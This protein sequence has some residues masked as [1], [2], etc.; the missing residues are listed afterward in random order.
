MVAARHPVCDAGS[1]FRCH[2]R[3]GHESPQRDNIASRH[4][5]AHGLSS[6]EPSGVIPDCL[7]PGRW[8][9]KKT[10]GFLPV[11]ILTISISKDES[12][13]VERLRYGRSARH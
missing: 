7:Q 4:F 5:A 9:G 1:G 13:V 2:S 11:A 12:G 8:S 3:N 10:D 6:Q